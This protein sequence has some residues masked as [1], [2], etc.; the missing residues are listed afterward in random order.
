[1]RKNITANAAD[2]IREEESG[3]IRVQDNAHVVVGGLV[4]GKT[5]KY[6]RNNQQMAF[7]TL[8]DLTGS[9]EIIVFPKDYEKYRH[10]LEEEAKIFVTG[11][12]TV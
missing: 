3:E 10:L 4:T 5:V 9:V 11:R 2:F 12:A 8:E 7:I 6:T 1:M